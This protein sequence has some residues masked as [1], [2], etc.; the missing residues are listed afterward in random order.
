MKG[1][2]SRI[3]S[4]K[5][6]SE[7]IIEILW[8]NIIHTSCNYAMPPIFMPTQA[9]KTYSAVKGPTYPDKM[10]VNGFFAAVSRRLSLSHIQHSS[11]HTMSERRYYNVF[12][13]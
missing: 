5:K 4:T 7:L 12:L 3:D 8:T 11:G 1:F 13:T 2:P 10:F 9:T 6:L